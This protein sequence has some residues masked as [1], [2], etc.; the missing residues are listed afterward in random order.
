MQ[1]STRYVCDKHRPCLRYTLAKMDALPDDVLMPIL[2]YLL[3][4]DSIT[5]T[6][7]ERALQDLQC[8]AYTCHRLLQLA[9]PRCE[10]LP[11]TIACAR[12]ILKSPNPE[13]LFGWV[14]FRDDYDQRRF[15]EW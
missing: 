7:T 14:T 9:A 5:S 13:S 10:L 11:K 6:T 4:A 3:P 12:D 1:H 2:H 8:T 15:F